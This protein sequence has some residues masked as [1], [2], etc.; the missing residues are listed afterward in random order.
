MANRL[1]KND[2]AG[3]RPRRFRLIKNSEVIKVGDWISDAS[4]GA[5]NTDSVSKT[6]L[7]LV[8]AI[9]TPQKVS[10]ES[11]TVTTGSYGGAWAL[12]TKQYTA[13]ADNQTVDGI[14]VEYI[15]CKE[16]DQ[17]LA[18]LS[19][20]KGATTGSD[21]EG[22]YLAIK[23]T[24]SSKLDEATAST[25]STNTQF[26]IVDGYAAGATTEVIVEVI[27]RTEE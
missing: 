6:I 24:D 7:G 27:T 15:P 18:T 5:E 8:T 10:F 2:R 1:Y 17:F 11:A 14:M 16:G 20:A 3:N 4:T 22:Y 13:A 19:A 25:S 9:V 12:S 23:T 26:R 21:K